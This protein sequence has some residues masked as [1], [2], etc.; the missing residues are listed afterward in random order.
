[1]VIVK[2]GESMAKVTVQGSVVNKKFFPPEGER[3]AQFLISLQDQES[4]Q[5]FGMFVEEKHPA[6]E[7]EVGQILRCTG[8]LSVNKS[9]NYFN[10]NLNDVIDVKRYQLQEVK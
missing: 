2:G 4:G 10:L 5:R 1:M 6:A 8:S 3:D 9:G 7:V